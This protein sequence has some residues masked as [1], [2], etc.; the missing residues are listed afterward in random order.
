MK[1]KMS[2]ALI[3]LMM[4]A[5]LSACGTKDKNTDEV[6]VTKPVE[7]TS[8]VETP[9]PEETEESTSGNSKEVVDV[10]IG[11]DVIT[12]N[13]FTS[14][15]REF[16]LSSLP[17]IHLL[18]PSEDVICTVEEGDVM[19]FKEYE[20]AVPGIEQKL[21]CRVSLDGQS[22]GCY[23]GVKHEET[24]EFGRYLLDYNW[25]QIAVYDKNTDT[26]MLISFGHAG[27]Y[28][29]EIDELIN[30]ITDANIEYI[31]QQITG[32]SQDETP[33]TTATETTDENINEEIYAEINPDLGTQVYV[34]DGGSR[35]EIEN[36]LSENTTIHAVDA[37]GYTYDFQ[38]IPVADTFYHAMDD[39]TLALY[40]DIANGK[41]SVDTDY[42]KY[43][44]LM[45]T[46][47]FEGYTMNY[48]K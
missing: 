32:W 8:V 28:S 25:C 37:V 21:K 34:T 23:C 11:G 27:E 30:S 5:V 12:V 1:K 7:D 22:D 17:E 26:A 38:L 40:V 41:M 42:E 18:I 15:K 36:F 4:I 45:S 10:V 14:P 9:K 3:C 46:S 48:E 31:K 20:I 6:T 24:L 35:I 44:N 29:D 47:Q 39:G 13:D 19:G 2:I 33:D 16:K 43:C